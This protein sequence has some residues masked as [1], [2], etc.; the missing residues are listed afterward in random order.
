MTFL[1]V[2][3]LD[4]REGDQQTTQWSEEP[5]GGFVCKLFVCKYKFLCKYNQMCVQVQN[6]KN[7]QKFDVKYYRLSLEN[8]QQVLASKGGNFSIAMM[9]VIKI[10]AENKSCFWAKI[11]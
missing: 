7:L 3:T 10:A 11:N 4:G 8:L 5:K 2:I 6:Q 9:K 1:I